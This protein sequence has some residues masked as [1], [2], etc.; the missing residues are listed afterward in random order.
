MTKPWYEY[1]DTQFFNSASKAYTGHYSAYGFTFEDVDTAQQCQLKEGQS[2]L[3]KIYDYQV[4]LSD[5][6]ANYSTLKSQQRHEI[7]FRRK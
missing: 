5:Q 3:D 1:V 2:K 4:E 6:E 7:K